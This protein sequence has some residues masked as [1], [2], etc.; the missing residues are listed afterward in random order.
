MPGVH[1]QLFHVYYAYKNFFLRPGGAHA[2]TE[3][4]GYAY[5]MTPKLKI[6]ITISHSVCRQSLTRQKTTEAI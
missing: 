3:T 2:P 5:A 6:C 4:T 1:L